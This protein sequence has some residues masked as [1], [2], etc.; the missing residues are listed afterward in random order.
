M[1]VQKPIQMKQQKQIR[2]EDLLETIKYQ[3]LSET[4]SQEEEQF[5]LILESLR[6]GDQINFK[7]YSRKYIDLDT[8]KMQKF[9]NKLGGYQNEKDTHS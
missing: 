8:E 3:P 4:I 1:N 9:N 2:L 7:H 6:L 5:F